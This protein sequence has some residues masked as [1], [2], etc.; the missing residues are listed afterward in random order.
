MRKINTRGIEAANKIMLM[1]AL[2]YNLKKYMK[3]L[4]KKMELVAN[5]MEQ[6]ALLI[7][8]YIQV[9]FSSYQLLKIERVHYS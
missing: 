6:A 3:H 2:A 4:P 1:A 9:V 5:S 7:F 8:T